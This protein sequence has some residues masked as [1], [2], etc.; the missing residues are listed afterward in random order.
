MEIIITNK[1]EDIGL[2]DL[3]RYNIIDEGEWVYAFIIKNET[4][5]RFPYTIVDVNT[6]EELNSYVSL[7]AINNATA[8]IKRVGKITKMEVD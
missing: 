2:G 6:F 1:V 5:T 8:R 4:S 7:S 3:V